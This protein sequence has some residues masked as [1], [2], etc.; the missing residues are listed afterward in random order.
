M[1]EEFLNQ[2]EV[3]FNIS[4]CNRIDIDD[5]V[6]KNIDLAILDI[7]FCNADSTGI[8]LAQ[9]IQKINQWIAVIFVTCHPEY[10]MD[11]FRL[12]AQGYIEKPINKKHL[13]IV[14]KKVLVYLKGINFETATF[15]FMFERQKVILLQKNIIYIEKVGRKI[16]I[17]T[18][19]SDYEI[20]EGINTVESRLV[21]FFLKIN[22]G[23]LVNM[24]YIAEIIN[25]N[26]YL[27]NG[28]NFRIARNRLNEVKE[29]Y[30]LFTNNS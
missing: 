11:A 5:E 7:D 1:I 13:D 10:A 14:L 17:D 3:E 25:Y 15:E 23:T 27:S 28:M 24:N 29:K 18:R 4:C 12:H 2:N 16:K 30:F 8:N 21:H 22:S 26:I 6:I 9:K 20:N 19:Q